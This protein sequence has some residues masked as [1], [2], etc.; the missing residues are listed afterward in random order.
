[1]S[2]TSIDEPDICK[3]ILEKKN[4]KRLLLILNCNMLHDTTGRHFA[5]NMIAEH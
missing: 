3:I 4:L 1:M 2:F 5:E